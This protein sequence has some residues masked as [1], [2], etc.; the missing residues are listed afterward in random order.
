MALLA[1]A[2]VL[3]QQYRALTGKPLGITGEV[4]EYEASRILKVE[5]TPARQAGYDAIE[6]VNGTVRRLQ[7]K[8]R[9]L[10][11]NCKPGQRLG[12]IDVTKDFDGVLLVLVDE[13]FNATAIY[14]ADREHVL[15]V[16][17]EPGSKSR[18]ERGALGVSKFKSI[19]R[20]RWTRMKY[21]HLDFSAKLSTASPPITGAIVTGTSPLMF[22]AWQPSTWPAAS[23][24]APEEFIE[25]LKR[26]FE[27]S[28]LG[29]VRHVIEDITKSNGT[30]AFRGH[31]VAIAMMCALDAI[32]PYGY[33][34]Q[35]NG[36]FI[37]AHFPAQYRPY[38]D[39]IYHLF[40]S[41]MVHSWNLFEASIYADNSPI[42]LE[43]GGTL[44]FGLLNFFDALVA[45]AEDFLNSL[46][47]GG[48]LLTNSV[49]RYEKLRA[50]AK[51]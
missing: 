30:L 51:P 4:A 19:A 2:K 48:D 36:K 42:R 34:R 18:N 20:L 17:A 22:A 49:N 6:T 43:G 10:L 24:S 35:N 50:T 7:I 41:S 27:E 14:E 9:C 38:A 37:A 16:L 8:G 29:E 25:V 44:A 13:N 45:G 12:S 31:V 3:A 28:I 21:Y 11:K 46:P 15:R 26:I 39:Q 33:R 40:R 32:S 1:Q 5:L 47:A 23:A